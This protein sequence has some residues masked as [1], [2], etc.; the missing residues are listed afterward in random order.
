MVRTSLVESGAQEP[1]DAAPESEERGRAASSAAAPI[2]FLDGAV[3][4]WRRLV[5]VREAISC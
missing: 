3:P 4:C 5:T 2:I 1:C